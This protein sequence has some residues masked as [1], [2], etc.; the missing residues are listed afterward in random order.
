MLR[1]KIDV[2][3]VGHVPQQGGAVLAFNHHSYA[4]FIALGWAVVVDAGR[5]LRFL[6]KREVWDSRWV[7]WAPRW[8]SAIPVERGSAE[9]RA[10]AFDAAVQALEAG[11]LVAVAPE[12]TLSASF[13]LLPFR[14]GAVR[15]AQQAQVPIIPVAGWG[16]QRL[17]AKGIPL[18]PRLGIPVTVR[19]GIPMRFARNDDPTRAM[20]EVRKTM[21]VMLDEI[22]RAYPDGMP[23]GEPWVPARLGGSAPAHDE[24]LRQHQQRSRDW[25]Q[26]IGDDT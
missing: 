24:V 17:A 5:P 4:D 19:F 8:I 23:Q 18:R 12:Q 26:A 3:G 16:S 22:Q 13:E 20:R 25:D 2:Q 7:G 11:D 10:A 21:A 14:S 9:G 15:M 1:T 6:G